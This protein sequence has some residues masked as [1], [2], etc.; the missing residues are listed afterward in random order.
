[1]NP[2]QTEYVYASSYGIYPGDVNADEFH[3]MLTDE[4]I[5]NRT[6]LLAD[7]VYIFSATVEF[8]SD[9]SLRGGANTVIKLDE[10]SDSSV[11]FH[12]KGV[13]NVSISNLTIQGSNKSRP[14]IK[15]NISG[16]W[17]DS[18]RSINIENVD[19]VG[20]GLYGIYA[21]TMSSYG[22]AEEGKFYKQLQILNT[23]FYNNYC[24]SY[25][26]YR[27]EY[28]QILNCVFGE[29]YIG[30]VNCGGN[31]MYVS[32]M[33]NSNLYGFIM[34]NNGSNP[35]HGG[36]NSCTFNHNTYAIQ[37]NDCVNGWTFDGCQVFYGKVELLNSIGVI[38]N[39]NIWGSCY[40]K[41]SNGRKNVN[42]ITSSYFLTDS[43]QIL[44]ENDGS[45]CVLNCLP[46]H[47]QQDQL[48]EEV[49]R[50][51][52][53]LFTGEEVREWKPLSTN[54][55]SCAYAYPVAVGVEMDYIDFVVVNA[56]EGS[57]VKKI[58]L[59]IVNKDTGKVM[60]HLIKDEDKEVF[61]SEDLNS[62]V[63]RFE[64]QKNDSYPSIFIVQCERVQGI[65]IAYYQ[66]DKSGSGW[67][68]GDV[69]PELG[70]MINGNS[71]IVPVYAIYQ[72]VE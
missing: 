62:Y 12:L 60:E 57:V 72:K 9:I 23:R 48:Q 27:C 29:N 56:V 46:D 67:L 10:N 32:C 49:S 21:K 70:E 14:S 3:N 58:N 11:L 65:S 2:N 53:I 25:F 4:S 69:A 22:S 20:W 17:I 8:V 68:R 39:A 7:G 31:N 5:K 50:D 36:C 59:W 40:F 45:T 37:V 61:F 19:I 43:N 54:A 18:C 24:G 16:I 33:W 38:F 51:N 35:A 63:V 42:L 47:I 30:S 44:K 34:N 13:D 15:G 1:M 28:T 71:N 6:I 26:D 55:Y 52:R 41:S 66:S 64:V